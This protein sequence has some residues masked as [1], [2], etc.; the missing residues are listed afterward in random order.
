MRIAQKKLAEEYI[1]LLHQAHQGIKKAIETKKR[2]ITEDLLEQCQ[3]IAIR[4]GNMIEETEGENFAAIPLLEDYCERI[5]QIYVKN[6]QEETI[7]AGKAY[8]GLRQLWIRIEHCIKY[9]IEVRIEA[10]FLPYKASMWDS[11]ES[12]WKAADED[13]ACDAYVIPIPYY[14]KNPD[15]SFG[16]EHYEG[17]QYPDD[18]PVTRY[19]TYDFETRRP[20]MIFI[21]NPY[22]ECN[23]VTSVHPFFYSKN[24]KLFTDLLVYMPYFI[25][26]D[27]DL[28]DPDVEEGIAHFCTCPGVLHADKVI[29]QSEGMRKVYVD[30]MTRYTAGCGLTRRHWEKKILGLG[31]PKVEKIINTRK[32]E[33]KIPEEWIQIIQKSD[34]TWKKLCIYNTGVSALLQYSEKYLEK[35]KEALLVFKEAQDKIALLWR[36]H[37]LI[38]ETIVSMRPYLLKQY[39]RIVEQYKKEGWGIY[40]DTPDMD[41]AIVLADAYYGDASSMVQLCHKAGIPV[42]IQKIEKTD[43]ILKGNEQECRII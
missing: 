23:Y 15:G 8:K 19:D 13:P 7:H 14:D 12:V 11:M 36:P 24:L 34:G 42:M 39:E 40:D 2:K 4:L 41:R 26:G 28:N 43:N 29:V 16:K 37:P 10:V 1:R 22:D 18:V 33:L 3:E 25:L 31:S 35:M 32:E 30:V 27:P 6:R 21:H 5:Y 17:D 20:D 38:Q 9:E